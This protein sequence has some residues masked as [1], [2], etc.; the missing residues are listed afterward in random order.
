VR[1][2]WA[3]LDSAFIGIGP[4]ARGFRFIRIEAAERRFG[5]L[6]AELETLSY[7]D[8]VYFNRSYCFPY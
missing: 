8:R 1:D 7:V 3:N 5:K 4:E 2:W 6:K